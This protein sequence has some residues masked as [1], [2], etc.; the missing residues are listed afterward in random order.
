[1]TEKQQHLLWASIGTILLEL[2]IILWF[3]FINQSSSSSAELVPGKRSLPQITLGREKIPEIP[4]EPEEPPQ[5]KPSEPLPEVIPDPIETP[6]KPPEPQPED[7]FYDDLIDFE[8]TNGND[9]R[10]ESTSED[11]ASDR[12]REHL[13]TNRA[14]DI[15]IDNENVKRQ[16]TS[17][18]PNLDNSKV[19]RDLSGYSE[20]KIV[21]DDFSKEKRN[22]SNGNKQTSA[23]EF[24]YFIPRNLASG[25]D[26]EVEKLLQI[27]GRYMRDL[28]ISS[29]KDIDSAEE[30]KLELEVYIKEVHNEADRIYPI[31][32]NKSKAFDIKALEN[33]KNFLFDQWSKK[34]DDDDFMDF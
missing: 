2:L 24:R 20:K 23:E 34:D 11:I 28:N 12:P 33:V 21:D 31:P 6:V 18:T 14:S 4:F 10:F 9:R 1:M 25:Y 27:I 30:K 8:D 16:L 32:K 5:V 3:P 13:L 19:E 29:T 15:D 7:D 17:T 22:L 26:E